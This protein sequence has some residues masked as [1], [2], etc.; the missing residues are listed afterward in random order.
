MTHNDPCTP[1][2]VHARIGQGYLDLARLHRGACQCLPVYSTVRAKHQRQAEYLESIAAGWLPPVA[3]IKP[4]QL[5]RE[6]LL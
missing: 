3:H 5:R 4:E 1:S 2:Q 6:A